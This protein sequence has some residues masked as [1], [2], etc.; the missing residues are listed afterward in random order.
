MA[1]IEATIRWFARTL[2]IAAGFILLAMSAITIASVSGRALAG[3][4]IRP[5]RG[6]FELIEMGCAIVVFSVLPWCQVMR[7]HVTVDALAERLPARIG[8]GLTI[9]GNVAL[10][11]CSGVI[12]WRLWLGFGE[13]FPFGSD[14]LRA[15]LSLGDKPFYVETS[16]ELLIPVWIPYVLCLPGAV[17]FFVTCLW[18]V[19][20]PSSQSRKVA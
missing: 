9:I 18:S 13:R 17:L 19:A 10:S 5:I 14:I 15:V 12:L 2:A 7:G 16:Y 4:G 11:L 20:M 3:L 8:R 1:R 6:D